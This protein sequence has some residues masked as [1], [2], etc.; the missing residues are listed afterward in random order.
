MQTTIPATLDIMEDEIPCLGIC[1]YDP[2]TGVCIG[3]GRVPEGVDVPSPGEPDDCL[4]GR[5]EP[6]ADSARRVAEVRT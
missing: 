3:C 1:Q 6:A 5:C 4:H 2:E